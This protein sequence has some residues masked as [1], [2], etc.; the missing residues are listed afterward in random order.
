MAQHDDKTH[1]AM[2]ERELDHAISLLTTLELPWRLPVQAVPEPPQKRAAKVIG[3]CDT[4]GQPV[5]KIE[6]ASI[7]LDGRVRLEI[8]S[9]SKM[10]ILQFASSSRKFPLLRS[11]SSL[12]AQVPLS[13][14][15]S[16]W[17][18]RHPPQQFGFPA[19][20]CYSFDFLQKGIFAGP[21]ERMLSRRFTI[22][23]HS[24]QSHLISLVP[25]QEWLA[26]EPAEFHL[27][28]RE[29]SNIVIRLLPEHMSPGQ[30]QAT[31]QIRWKT[32]KV[33]ISILAP[34][35]RAEPPVVLLS[36]EL[37][38]PIAGLGEQAE[39]A[40]K[41]DLRRKGALRGAVTD[42]LHRIRIP[43]KASGNAGPLEIPVTLPTA[44][45][46]RAVHFEWPLYVSFES[47]GIFSTEKVRVRLQRSLRFDPPAA[48]LTGHRP[49]FVQI[50]GAMGKVQPRTGEIPADVE[51]KVTDELLSIRR[52]GTATENKRMEWIVVEDKLSGERADL[53]VLFQGERL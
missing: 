47:S 9:D 5:Q 3:L 36:R 35:G 53:A 37:S 50:K 31:L 22:R 51:V 40:L 23:N 44:E 29:S 8:P 1:P 34:A 39:I 26:V 48:I 15:R 21:Q 25:N 13:L 30:N 11:D 32:D 2:L 28:P 16:A 20:G 41:F 45:L 38:L 49:A 43:F 14:E 46:F 12:V 24:A 10:S 4:L 17:R 42:L 33:K 27:R 52:K 18:L 7:T 19:T 6:F